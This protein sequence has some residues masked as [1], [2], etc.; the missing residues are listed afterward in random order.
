MEGF[1]SLGE[2]V[3]VQFD[4]LSDALILVNSQ[5]ID[6]HNNKIS[7]VK[8]EDGEKISTDHFVNAAGPF[9]GQ[10]AEK[11]NVQLPV[12]HHLHICAIPQLRVYE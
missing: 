7:M 11:M 9:L 10:V 8:L 6:I 12:F 2:T 3:H 5:G 1:P 4:P